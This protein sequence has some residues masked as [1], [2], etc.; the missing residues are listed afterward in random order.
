VIILGA[1]V[2]IL[3]AIALLNLDMGGDDDGNY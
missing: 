2:I 1:A 3:I